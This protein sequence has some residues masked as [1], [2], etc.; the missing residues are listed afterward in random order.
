MRSNGIPKLNL[1]EIQNQHEKLKEYI[2]FTPAIEVQTPLVRKLFNNGRL[3]LKLECMQHTGTFK[4]RGAL[5]SVLSMAPES[6]KYG[7]TAVSAGNHAIAA[8]WAAR[9]KNLS[10]KVVMQS[11]ANAYRI[12]LAQ[13]EGAEVILAEDGKAAF[14]MADHLVEIEKRTFIHPFEGKYISLGTSGVG[15]EFLESV[16]ELDAIIVSVGGGGLISGIAAA[17]KQIKADCMVYGVEP[18][19]AASV[20][21]SILVNKPVTLQSVSTIADSLAPPMSL[22][23]S[24]SL[25][26]NYVDKIVTVT[27]DE[28]CGAMAVYQQEFKLAVEPAAA[29]ALAAACG[30]LRERLKNKNI[31]VVVCGAN[32]D[33]ETYLKLMN[34][35]IE[36]IKSGKGG[37]LNIL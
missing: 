4:A 16:K 15:F 26:K 14:A 7:I 12:A 11:S 13:S 1:S 35:G 32:I 10:A 33:C 23:Y 20:S 19:G 3:F 30:P 18:E 36:L 9:I 6:E 21:K 34:K 2:K 31:G 28:I 24:F 37:W 5:S 29:A 25:I 17:V 8:A 27:D 22:P